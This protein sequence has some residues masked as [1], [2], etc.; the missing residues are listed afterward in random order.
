MGLFNHKTNYSEIRFAVQ[1]SAAEPYDVLFVNR[2]D[3]IVSAYCTC[4]AGENGMICKH[5][6]GIIRDPLP[7]ILSGSGQDVATVRDWIKG[8]DIEDALNRL[9]QSERELD[10][11]KGKVSKAKKALAAAMLK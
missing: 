3:G 5:R 6:M 7:V 4:Q 1:G 2:G 11:A 8:S 10:A 9:D